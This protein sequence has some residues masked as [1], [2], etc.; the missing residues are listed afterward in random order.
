MFKDFWLPVGGLILGLGIFIFV[1]VR[2][3]QMYFE[4]TPLTVI[5]DKAIVYKGPA[6]GVD[7]TTAGANTQVAVY[8][9]G[10]WAVKLSR[11]YCSADVS[12]K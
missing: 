4:S 8:G 6:Y 10:F 9:E 5:V 11:Y 7:V 2:G 3:C 12:I 1:A